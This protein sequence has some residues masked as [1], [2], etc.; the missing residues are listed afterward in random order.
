MS[1]HL[2][3]INESKESA[4]T[5]WIAS[6]NLEP[7]VMGLIPSCSGHGGVPLGKA[8]FPSLVLVCLPRDHE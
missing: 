3:T 7:G 6:G 2:K 5:K 1:L 4:I 8:M